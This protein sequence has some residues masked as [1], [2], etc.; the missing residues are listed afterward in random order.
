MKRSLVSV[1]GGLCIVFSGF[2]GWASQ[3]P[4]ALTS[5]A[6]ALTTFK[7][8]VYLAWEGDR[9]VGTRQTWFATF[10]GGTWSDQAEI[11]GSFTTTAPALAATSQT[12]YLA[13]TPPNTGNIDIYVLGA[14]GFTLLGPLCQGTTCAETVASP[15]LFGVG[16]VLYAAWTTPTGSLM[17]AEYINGE[18][19][20]A[21]HPIANAS[22]SSD[23]GP[24]LAAFEDQL[25]LAWTDAPAGAVSVI[26]TP[27]PLSDTSW[28]SP[29]VQ[30][31][32]STSVAP[33]LG[34][35]TAFNSPPSQSLFLA[36]TTAAS[37]IR[38]AEHD[39]QTGAWNLVGS[40]IPLPKGALTTLAPALNGSV[41][42][43]R[44][45]TCIY[46]NDVAYTALEPPGGIDDVRQKHS[47]KKN[48]S[49]CP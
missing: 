4:Q 45:E 6:P 36:W 49:G 1:C 22:S 38:F 31:A 33:A 8:V 19:L 27:L 40:P 7:D 42:E 15:A 11:P 39:S 9:A 25:Y 43:T 47:F 20:I 18:W 17:Y 37:T 16:S 3:V 30:V 13:I 5:G 34:V 46:T 26:S 12:V 41:Y 10:D 21:P 2:C 35:F 23:R 29:A 14:N 24:A 44:T 32:A 48:L 28:S